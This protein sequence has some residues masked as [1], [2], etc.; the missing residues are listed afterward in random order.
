M[1]SILVNII[2][3][4]ITSK[5]VVFFSKKSYIKYRQD[6]CTINNNSERTKK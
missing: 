1:Y 5:N 3:K 6:I 4:K 2:K